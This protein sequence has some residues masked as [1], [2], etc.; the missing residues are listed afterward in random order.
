MIYK[1]FRY[2]FL[3][4]A[5]ATTIYSINFIQETKSAGGYSGY[6]AMAVLP[7]LIS[8]IVV[9]L[10]LAIFVARS[11]KIDSTQLNGVP[12]NKSAFANTGEMVKPSILG[13]SFLVSAYLIV[14][15]FS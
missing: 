5:G 3:L 14:T 7:L 1:F 4:I 8:I 2:W 10:C 15:S 11:K 6:F 9:S 12:Q 13:V